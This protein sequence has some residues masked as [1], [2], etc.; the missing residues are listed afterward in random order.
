MRHL[1]LV[2]S[3]ERRVSTD[4]RRIPRGG[5]RTV[6]R[7]VVIPIAPTCDGCGSITG[8]YWVSGTGTFDEYRCLECG[9]S[10]FVAR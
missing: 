7:V 9:T 6:D 2:S 8:P 1:R 3:R 5:R 4:R 10:L